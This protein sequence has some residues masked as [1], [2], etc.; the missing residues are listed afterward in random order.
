M[1]RS[2]IKPE[3]EIFVCTPASMIA[4]SDGTNWNVKPGE[5]GNKEDVDPS[6]EPNPNDGQGA[7]EFNLWDED[8][9]DWE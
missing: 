6:T 3:A 7:K 1:R 9:D 2:Y 8:E 4:E 5:S